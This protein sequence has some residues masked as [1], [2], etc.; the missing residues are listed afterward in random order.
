MRS[1]WLEWTPEMGFVGFDGSTLEDFSIKR[2]AKEKLTDI[3]APSHDEAT[4]KSADCE[5]TK[6]SK[7]VHGA[8]GAYSFGTRD[9]SYGR[10]MHIALDAICTIP[11]PEGLIVWLD[12]NSPSLYDTLTRDLPDKISR[13]W[14][15]RVPLEAFDT[16]CSRWVETYRFAAELYHASI[17]AEIS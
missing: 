3:P 5:P 8:Q 2:G 17:G 6:P 4:E 7:P 10:R 11:A 13:A 9:D 14:N 16:L 1:K 12:G 15:A